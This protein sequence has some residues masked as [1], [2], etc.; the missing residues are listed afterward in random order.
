MNTNL[1][2]I[3]LKVKLVEF[4]CKIYKKI[5]LMCINNATVFS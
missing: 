1:F 3:A 4:S 5:P 2:Q